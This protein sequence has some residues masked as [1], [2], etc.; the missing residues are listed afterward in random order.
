MCQPSQ[1]ERGRNYDGKKKATE[2]YGKGKE[3]I[4]YYEPVGKARMPHSRQAHRK[5][6]SRN[7]C[8]KKV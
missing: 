4:K 8:R 3:S 1:N 2:N 7:D 5:E 6:D